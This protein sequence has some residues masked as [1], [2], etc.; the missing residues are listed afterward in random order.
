M[1]DI[2][3]TAKKRKAIDMGTKSAI[4][5]ELSA[6][7]KNGELCKKYGLSKSTISTIAKE[8]EKIMAAMSMNGD[9]SARKRLRH[10]AYKDVEDA[11]F[12]WFLDARTMNVPIS[13]PLLLGKARDFAFLLN[14]TEFSPG[15]GWLHRFKERH[16]IVYKSIVGEGASVD[17]ERAE[18]WLADNLDEIYSYSERDVYNADETALFYQMRPVRTHALKGDKCVGG[19]HSKVRITVLLCCNVDGSDR[20]LPF[21][22]G[23]AKKPRCFTNPLPVRYRDSAKA[24]MTRQLFAEWLTEL[25]NA[26]VKQKRKILLILDNCS[27]HHVNPQLNAVTLMF[28]PP[29]A[30]AKL[31]PLDMG[32]IRNF[33]VCYRRRVIER[34]LIAIGRP[35]AR[36]PQLTISLMNAV[37]MLKASWM[38]VRSGSIK[39]CFRKAGISFSPA[40]QSPAEASQDDAQSIDSTLWTQAVAASL[41]EEGQTWDDFVDADEDVIVS[42]SASDEAIVR[43]VRQ[44]IA[45]SDDEEDD[46]DDVGDGVAPSPPVSTATALGHIASL[47]QLVYARGLS[48]VHIDQLS[49]L[50]SAIIGSALR[51]QTAITDFLE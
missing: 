23:T 46:E 40:K 20:R 26:M 35:S 44:D 28:L 27:A 17:I 42:E 9:C 8:K 50:E 33:K 18:Q 19:K 12:K 24:W 37:E 3:S 4:L 36:G 16:G 25:D 43:E 22:I 48:D 15:N 30:T 45:A 10:A 7:A 39:N 31:Q 38:E 1:S 14:F 13:G 2:A 5:Q 34:L 41:T 51:K 47:K 29:N 32:I 11:L 49:N 6:G 21:V